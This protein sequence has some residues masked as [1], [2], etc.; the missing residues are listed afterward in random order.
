[1]QIS[2]T[3]FVLAQVVIP[4]LTIIFSGLL[5]AI[6]TH[7]LSSTRADREFRLKRLE[8]LF[9]SLQRFSQNFLLIMTPLI[10]VLA[11]QT[12]YSET[13]KTIDKHTDSDAGKQLQTVEML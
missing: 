3:L 9:V 4:L 12:T 11:G 8:E 10:P 7:W 5:S 2:P 6:I 13:E 1:M